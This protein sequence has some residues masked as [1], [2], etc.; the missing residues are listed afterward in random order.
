MQQV[1]SNVQATVGVIAFFVC[2]LLGDALILMAHRSDPVFG[3]MLN[4][5]AGNPAFWSYEEI[6]ALLAQDIGAG[7]IVLWP[8]VRL[9]FSAAV[10]MLVA[11]IY[12]RFAVIALWYKR[13][14]H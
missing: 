3:W 8:Q 14:S 1:S 7:G 4:H 2:L 12:P 9:A 6:I 5:L 11:W 13:T 10:A